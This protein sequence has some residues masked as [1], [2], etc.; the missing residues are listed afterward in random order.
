MNILPRVAAE[1]F[2]IVPL[3]FSIYE[4]FIAA[5]K[6]RIKPKP[7]NIRKDFRTLKSLFAHLDA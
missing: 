7:N 1:T 3:L 4:L 2:S 6:M 5:Q